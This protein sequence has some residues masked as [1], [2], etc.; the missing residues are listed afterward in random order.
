LWS[1]PD[2]IEWLHRDFEFESIVF[3]NA[4]HEVHVEASPDAIF[5]LELKWFVWCIGAHSEF[6]IGNSFEC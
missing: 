1:K 4:A 2:A 5:V 6:A 3:G